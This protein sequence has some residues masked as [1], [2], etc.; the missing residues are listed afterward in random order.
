MTGIYACDACYHFNAVVNTMAWFQ[1]DGWCRNRQPVYQFVCACMCVSAC[2]RGPYSREDNP[3]Q[4]LRQILTRLK[5]TYCGNIGYEYMHI[6]DREM[7]NWRGLSLPKK[8]FK[9]IAPRVRAAARRAALTRQK[10]MCFFVSLHRLF[11][12][13][14]AS[15]YLSIACLEKKTPTPTRVYRVSQAS[16]LSSRVK[17]SL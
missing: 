11:K 15:L 2:V 6:A 13:K 12:K 9:V 10:K 8:E 4:T 17:Y 1:Y 14:C 3:V 7:C 16:T 5:E